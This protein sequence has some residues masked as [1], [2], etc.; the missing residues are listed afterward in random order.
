MKK[1]MK[2]AVLVAALTLSVNANAQVKLGVKGGINTS[3]VSISID[4]WKAENRIGYFIGPTIKFNLPILGLG[5]DASA[6][7]EKREAKVTGPMG[8]VNTVV[9]SEQVI[10]PINARFSFG[11]SE[12]ADIFVFGGPQV[13]VNLG[14]QEQELI[15]KFADWTLKS[16]AFS[17]NVG[18]GIFL[19]NHLQATIGYNIAL[20]STGDVVFSVDG[21]KETRKK[22]DVRN[23]VWQLGVAYYF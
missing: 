14:K 1:M 17:V 7:Y 21:I 12:S 4:D 23:N 16:S 22:Y 10:V 11:L 8:L 19:A 5:M 15:P 3:Q 20:G 2:M 6:L 9:K 13:A 18:A